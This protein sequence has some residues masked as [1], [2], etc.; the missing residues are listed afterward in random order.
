MLLCCLELAP[1][2]PKLNLKEHAKTIYCFGCLSNIIENSM[3]CSLSTVNLS[4]VH[5]VLNTLLF[6]S[7]H[8]TYVVLQK[9]NYSL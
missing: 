4:S 3:L 5:V 7:T 2:Y 9:Y 1:D 6:E 8:S